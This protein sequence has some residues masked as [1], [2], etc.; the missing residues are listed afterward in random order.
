MSAGPGPPPPPGHAA[1]PPGT[2]G[3]HPP[4]TANSRPPPTRPPATNTGRRRRQTRPPIHGQGPRAKCGNAD[5]VLLAT[6]TITSAADKSI[7]SHAGTSPSLQI[8]TGGTK[9]LFAN[10]DAANAIL[11]TNETNNVTQAP[12]GMVVTGPLIID[13]AQPGYS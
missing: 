12:Q 9:Y 2:T 11:E 7:G 13:N 1:Q 8:T 5:D 3:G 10:V 6:E 4:G